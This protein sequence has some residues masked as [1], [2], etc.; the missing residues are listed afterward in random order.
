MAAEPDVLP[1]EKLFTPSLGPLGD[2]ADPK[3]S[4]W[5]IVV[6]G[7]RRVSSLGIYP[8]SMPSLSKGEQNQCSAL[9]GF[10]LS[11]VAGNSHH[12]SKS[13]S[14]LDVDFY[15]LEEPIFFKPLSSCSPVVNEIPDCIW[16][17]TSDSVLQKAKDFVIL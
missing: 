9:A 15:T 14:C 8:S 12:E 17:T 6:K 4:D 1:L 11:H 10:N 5:A 3:F 13:F 2:E 7:E 16:P